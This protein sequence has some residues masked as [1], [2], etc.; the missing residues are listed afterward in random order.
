ML[1]HSDAG[2]GGIRPEDLELK[3]DSTWFG[4]VKQWWLMKEDPSQYN[5]PVLGMAST[6]VY[7]PLG[8]V[9]IKVLPLQLLS[10]QKGHPS[11]PQSLALMSE[12][13]CT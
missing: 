1:R 5:P 6:S 2:E 9:S 13:A 7:N 10:D 3:A 4:A 11:R 12:E 8:A